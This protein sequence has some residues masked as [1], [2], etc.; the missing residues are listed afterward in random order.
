MNRKGIIVAGGSG[1]RRY[2]VTQA[3][4]RQ[5]LPI[6]DRP[7]AYYPPATPML[8]GVREVLVLSMPNDTPRFE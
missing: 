5:L 7:M 8:A 6:Y 2:P 4:S 1:T 3:A